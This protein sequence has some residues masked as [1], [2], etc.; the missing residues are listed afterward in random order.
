MVSDPGTLSSQQRRVYEFVKDSFYRN[1]SMPTLREICHHMGWKAVGSAQDVIQALI[2]KHRLSRSP[3]KARG[4]QL[5]DGP[6]F[7]NI[8]ILGS[9]PAGRALEAIEHH[10]GDAIVPDFIRGPV[11]AVRVIGDSMKN[12]GIEDGDLAI[13]SQTDS[14]ENKDIIVAL[15]YG[16]TTIKRLV[17]KGRENWLYPE[18]DAYKPRRIDDPSFRVLGKVIGLHRYWE[19]F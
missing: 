13:V 18:N 9:A 15:S 8:P 11:F 5:V 19:N 14:A 4:L 17:K 6:S 16:E 12:A 10:E 3:L 1:G 2:E 7:R